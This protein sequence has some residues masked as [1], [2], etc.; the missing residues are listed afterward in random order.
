MMLSGEGEI[1]S[2]ME[3]YNQIKSDSIKN[4]QKNN[5]MNGL[6]LD[7]YEKSFQNRV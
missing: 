3:K 6:N 7:N 2:E 4:D 1:N 5:I